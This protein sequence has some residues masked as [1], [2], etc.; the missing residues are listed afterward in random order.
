MPPDN[1]K[2]PI[3][4]AAGLDPHSLPKGNPGD[5]KTSTPKVRLQFLARRLHALGPKPLFHFLDEIECGADLRTHLEEYS[6]LPA[7]LVK[8]YGGAEFLDPFNFVTFVVPSEPVAFA[9]SGGKGK[10]RFTP[11]RQRDFMALVQ[12]AAHRAMNGQ[13]PL[14]GPIELR[15]RAAYRVPTSWSKKRAAGVRWRIARPDADNIAKLV[16]DSCNE[17]I[18]RDDAR[19]RT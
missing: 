3:P 7:N 16:A 6:A 11:K 2:G 13:P 1:A 18:F 19:L 4:V 5:S 12:L 15:I 10:I 8:D 14:A 9:R 17:I